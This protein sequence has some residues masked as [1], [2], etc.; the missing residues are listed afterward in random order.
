V[1]QEKYGAIREE[2]SQQLAAG[3]LDLEAFSERLRKIE[4]Q[5]SA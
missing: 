1:T 4:G 5:G 3:T 2:V